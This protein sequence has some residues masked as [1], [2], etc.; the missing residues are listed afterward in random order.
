[1]GLSLVD[2]DR[3]RELLYAWVGGEPQRTLAGVDAE[4]GGE[5]GEGGWLDGGAGGEAGRL[6]VRLWRSASEEGV[7]LSARWLQ[8]D[9]L[10][11]S[12]HHPVVLARTPRAPSD[13]AG[14]TLAVT[15]VRGVFRGRALQSGPARPAPRLR[16]PRPRPRPGPAPI[17]RAR[18]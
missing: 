13:P 7:S 18:G 16:P 15:A 6:A 8:V 1:V 9:S 10:V 17:C 11:P 3:A 5:A 4:G 2:S 14:E 12:A